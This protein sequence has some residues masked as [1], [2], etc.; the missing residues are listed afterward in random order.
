MTHLHLVAEDEPDDLPDGEPTDE[1]LWLEHVARQVE[2]D[3][4]PL[5][6]AAWLELLRRALAVDEDD[7]PGDAA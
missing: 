7:E 6:V 1:Q 5:F 4:Q 3:A 2:A